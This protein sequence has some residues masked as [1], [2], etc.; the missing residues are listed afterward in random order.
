MSEIKAKEHA[1]E[2]IDHFTCIESLIEELTKHEEK[3]K[4][5]SR[6]DMNSLIKNKCD[7]LILDRINY[8]LD[9]IYEKVRFF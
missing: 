4:K 8:L 5:L 3:T 2:K 7:L 9:H 1:D 6:D